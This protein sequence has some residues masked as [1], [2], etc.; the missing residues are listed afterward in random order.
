MFKRVISNN[1]NQNKPDDGSEAASLRVSP[2]LEAFCTAIAA[3]HALLALL[4]A[5]KGGQ[6][7]KQ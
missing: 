6:Y 1:S 7:E 3:L 4:E 5:D 2:F